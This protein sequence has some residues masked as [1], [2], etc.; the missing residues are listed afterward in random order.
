MIRK[1]YPAGQGSFLTPYSAAVRF[2]IMW[3]NLLRLAFFT[4]KKRSASLWQKQN[5][6]TG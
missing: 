2:F 3:D 5:T 1:F 6:N 4:I